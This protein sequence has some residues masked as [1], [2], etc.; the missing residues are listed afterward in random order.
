M[1]FFSLSS[2]PI[3]PNKDD[4]ITKREEGEPCKEVTL[5]ETVKGGQY[6]NGTCLFIKTFG[7]RNNIKK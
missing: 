3:F 6:A 7:K 5:R 4:Y 1:V 2:H